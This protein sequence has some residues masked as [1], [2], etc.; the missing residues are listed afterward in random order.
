MKS[1]KQYLKEAD[2]QLKEMRLSEA[3]GAD[4]N[5]PTIKK[6][7]NQYQKVQE[8]CNVVETAI[9]DLDTL[10]GLEGDRKNEMLKEI[11]RHTRNLFVASKMLAVLATNLK[12]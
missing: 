2:K 3:D 9:N 6:I 11:R 1:R 12:K 5:A 10:S 8:Y 4:K 7:R